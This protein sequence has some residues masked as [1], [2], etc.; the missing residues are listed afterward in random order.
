ME[1]SLIP[2]NNRAVVYY[3]YKNH[4]SGFSYSSY[5]PEMKFSYEK[6]VLSIL[7]NND[8]FFTGHYLENQKG[9]RIEWEG[10]IGDLWAE[11]SLRN[12]W[13]CNMYMTLD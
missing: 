8:L 5:M 11:W 6:E 1:L 7:L 10:E 2:N 3:T 9:L 4:Q 12:S 13:S